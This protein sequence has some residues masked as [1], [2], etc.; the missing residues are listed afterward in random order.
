M[1]SII[2]T[3][4][5]GAIL[6]WFLAIAYESIMKKLNYI[7]EI[8]FRD[9]IFSHL[10]IT[11][12]LLLTFLILIFPMEE[13][14]KEFKSQI[15]NLKEI[16]ITDFINLQK[17]DTKVFNGNLIALPYNKKDN[18]QFVD[19]RVSTQDNAFYIAFTGFYDIP[20]Q[21]AVFQLNLINDEKT[22]E[23][24][25]FK[26]DR[27]GIKTYNLCNYTYKFSIPEPIRPE[28][29]KISLLITKELN[30]EKVKRALLK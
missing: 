8:K 1:I 25:D 28:T 29:H 26:I 13:Q 19:R 12:V 10:I 21:G 18:N 5:L 9:K 23:I 3:L 4:I 15:T 22:Q 30:I 24:Y 6:G 2:I 20:N 27:I 16:L 7:K 11:I 17:N 14:N